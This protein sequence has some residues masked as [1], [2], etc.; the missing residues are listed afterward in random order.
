MAAPQA[1]LGL[2]LVAVGIAIIVRRRRIGVFGVSR[3]AP[4]G[5]PTE[6]W[7]IL[8]ALIITNGVLQLALALN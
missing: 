4:A 2:V 5:I 7:L 6:V 3:G 1:V 8:G